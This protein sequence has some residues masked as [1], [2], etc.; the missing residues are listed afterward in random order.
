MNDLKKILFLLNPRL[1]IRFIILIILVIWGTILEMLS[2]SLLIPILNI[3]TGTLQD[4]INFL[5][6]NNLNFLI[7]FLDF[8]KILI[9][10]LVIYVLK[11]F[12][13][14]YL[15]H[16]QNDFIFTFFTVLLNRLYKKYIFKDYLF[17][18]KNNSG[19]LIRNL[20]SE[21]HQCSIGFMG[22]ISSI[23]IEFIII[24]G[25]I[26]ILVVYKPYEVISFVTLTGLVALIII[27]I[28][29]KKSKVLGKDRQKYSLINVN[30]IMQSFG[31]IKEIIVNSKEN[32]V[33]K[34]FY[35]N[36]LDLKKVNYLF[37]VLNQ[38]PKLILELLVIISI[39][40]LLFYLISSGVPSSEVI[41]FFGLLI[42]IFS[43]V[44]PSI[45]K[46][47][48]SYINLSYYRPAVELLFKELKNDNYNES[49][50]SL[51]DENNFELDF[52]EKIEMKDISFSYPDNSE[53]TLSK[54]NL[55][56]N[57][58][59]KI[60]IY[61]ESGSGKSTIIDILIGLLQPTQGKILVDNNDI[62]NNKRKWFSKIGYVPQNIF[63]NDDDIRNNIIFYDKEENIN[64]NRYKEAIKIAQL[65]TL[66]IDKDNKVNTNIGER[67]IQ[68]SGGQR[69]R[70]GLARSLYKNSE[71]LI[72]DESTNAL[73]ETNETNFLDGIFSLKSN[74]TIIIISHKR[75]I[76]SRC[77][78]ILTIKDKKI[79]ES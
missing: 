3:L 37:Q 28:L 6:E 61:G 67:G 78:R 54:A 55:I 79:I 17:H 11:I 9:I 1:K 49:E 41:I 24:I 7:P 22:A 14:L 2:I 36:S 40:G 68:L 32:E 29:K 58:G 38:M 33:I 73:D 53:E 18:L 57:K 46:L 47:S 69:Q 10:F 66:L 25:L 4:S 65:E 30:N 20:L 62:K 52:K 5:I 56:I 42:G 16:Y 45:Y 76:L 13:R 50:S 72:F 51:I 63:L 23:I 74:R 71:I 77:N 44:M 39:V 21:I 60:G 35:Y 31:G 8:K 26:S 19:I 34:K 12:F 43:R 59:D 75:A 70:I 27:L 64:L 15:I 48:T